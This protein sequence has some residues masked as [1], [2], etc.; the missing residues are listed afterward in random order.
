VN[1]TCYSQKLEDLLGD[2]NKDYLFS[3]IMSDMARGF[4]G[5]LGV[6]TLLAAVALLPC[7]LVLLIVAQ[8]ELVMRLASAVN[9]MLKGLCGRKKPGCE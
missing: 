4:F 7:S 3:Q 9:Q 2:Q 8:G 5:F 1:D 6:L